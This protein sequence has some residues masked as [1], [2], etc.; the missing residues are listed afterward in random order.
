MIMLQKMLLLLIIFLLSL[1]MIIIKCVVSRDENSGT[2]VYG[3]GIPIKIKRKQDPGPEGPCCHIHTEALQ[4][5]PYHILEIDICY[6]GW[7][8]TS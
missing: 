5:Y 4:L 3:T 7:M 8:N 1:L 6:L 2:S